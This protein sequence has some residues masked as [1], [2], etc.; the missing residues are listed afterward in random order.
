MDTPLKI[1]P[2]ALAFV[3]AMYSNQLHAQKAPP[4]AYSLALTQSYSQKTL[5]KNWALTACLSEISKDIS[6]KEDASATA[7]A[8][9]EYGKQG[10]EA[11]DAL[12]KLAHRYATLKYGGSIDSEFNMMKCIDLFHSKELDKLTN[13]LLRQKYN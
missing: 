1:L 3:L 8:Y 13:K 7:S 2:H 11:Y 9:L 6:F 10:L 5:L 12:R 4:S